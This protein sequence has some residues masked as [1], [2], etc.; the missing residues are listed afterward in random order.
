MIKFIKDFF[1]KRLTKK[2]LKKVESRKRSDDIKKA[3]KIIKEYMDMNGGIPINMVL[4][5]IIE[6]IKLLK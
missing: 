6:D 1:E 2:T 5:K 4:G 3:D